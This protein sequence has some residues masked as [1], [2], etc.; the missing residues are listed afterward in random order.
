M[1]RE[2][3]CGVVECARRG[4]EQIEYCKN[5]VEQ[6]IADEKMELLERGND[7][8]VSDASLR[9]L[10]NHLEL[11]LGNTFRFTLLA[12]VCAVLEECVNAIIDRLVPDEQERKKKL[13][14]A[15]NKVKVGKGWSNW[16]ES[17][18][19]LI[20]TVVTLNQTPQFESDLNKFSD[21]ITL[22][23]CIGHA[24]GNVENTDYPQQ[25]RDVVKRLEN[26]ARQQNSELAFISPAGRLELGRDMISYALD[27]VIPIIE[28][29]C[30]KM[31]ALP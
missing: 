28:F 7:G 29:V 24:W 5:L 8:T 13:R 12:G 31:T 22:R 6:K 10:W 2:F 21:V 20:S 25:V 15:E 30:D 16:L 17:R 9:Q 27:P 23:N 4:A 14:E 3:Y 11:T 26:E 19:Q 1:S 18:I